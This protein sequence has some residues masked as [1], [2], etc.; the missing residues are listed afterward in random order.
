MKKNSPVLQDIVLTSRP[1]LMPVVAFDSVK[2]L[3]DVCLMHC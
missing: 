1:C 2:T 3:F